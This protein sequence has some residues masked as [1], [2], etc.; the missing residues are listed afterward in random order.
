MTKKIL[1]A[2]AAVLAITLVGCTVPSNPG[3]GHGDLLPRA[4]RLLQVVSPRR[5][6]RYVRYLLLS[7]NS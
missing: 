2:L 6:W 4:Q 1:T 7:R 5:I 3:R